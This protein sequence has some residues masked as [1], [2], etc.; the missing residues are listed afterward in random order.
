MQVI[1]ENDQHDLPIGVGSVEPLVRLVLEMEACRRDEVGIHFVTVEAIS[2]LHQEYFDD[3]TPTDC[4]SFPADS[5]APYRPLGDVFVC[6]QIA[7]DYAREHQT[8]PYEEVTLYVV[9]GL[10][11][12]LGYGDQTEEEQTVMRQKEAEAMELLKKKKSLLQS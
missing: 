3:P 5:P 8:D 7:L 4:I 1:V 12:L 2:A 11:H 9:H 10:L 6:P